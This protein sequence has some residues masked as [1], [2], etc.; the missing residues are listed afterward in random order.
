MQ[1][2]EWMTRDVITVTEDTSLFR[3]SK[4]MKEH[5]I[6]RLPVVDERGRL[7]GIVSDRDIKA[8]SP[9]KA[10][11]LD[12]YELMYIL[13]EIRIRDVMTG[14][15]VRIGPEQTVETVALLMQDKGIGGIP[16][17]DGNDNILGIITDHDIFKV[18]VEI[19]G[20]R[21]GGLQL[22]FEVADNPDAS[23]LIIDFLRERATVVSML[24]SAATALSPG[25]RRIY[26][27]IESMADRE[28][29]QALLEEAGAFGL[30]Y[31]VRDGVQAGAEKPA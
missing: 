3:A 29:E 17:V 14:S 4:L 31:H 10:T 6:R 18:L 2:R 23:R 5:K 1:V 11:S 27:R 15:P 7:I 22:A 9:S 26:I 24:T 20:V 13:S 25:M 21:R 19:T 30:L 12:M 8:A 28:R 16:V